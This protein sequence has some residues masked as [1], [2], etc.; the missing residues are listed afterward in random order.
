MSCFIPDASLPAEY[1]A[2]LNT[3][4]KYLPD[5]SSEEKQILSFRETG[6]DKLTVS[7]TENGYR[8]GC[9]TKHAFLR[10]IG[11]AL[12]GM[13]TEETLPFTTL[14]VMLDCSRNRVFKVEFI[15]DFLLK[16][17]LTGYNMLMLYTEDV[18]ELPGEPAFGFMRGRYSAEEI[19]E[20]DAFAQ[21]LGIEVR[22]CIQTLGHLEHLFT[23]YQYA[24]I[25]DMKGILLA[26]EEKTYLLIEKMIRFYAENLHSKQILIGMD[27]THDLGRGKHLDKFGWEPPEAIY[28]RHLSKVCTICEKYKL[29]PMI[30]SDMLFRLSDQKTLRNTLPASLR[31]CHWNYSATDPAVYRTN[32]EHHQALGCDTAM[33]SAVP[34]YN[35]FCRVAGKTEQVIPACVQ[36]C[37]EAGIRELIITIWG[38]AGAFCNMTSAMAGIVFAASAAYGSRN[39]EAKLFQTLTGVDHSLLCE[40][41][42][43]QSNIGGTLIPVPGLLWEDPL[44]GGIYTYCFSKYEPVMRRCLQELEGVRRHLSKEKLSEPLQELFSIIDLL[45]YGLTFREELLRAYTEKNTAELSVL[46][47][48]GIAAYQQ[49][50]QTFDACF[51]KEWMRT[52]KPFGL[53]IIQRRNAGL[54]ARLDELALRIKEF[55]NGE[56][57]RIAE[58][59][60]ALHAASIPGFQPALPVFSACLEIY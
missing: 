37:M 45:L 18:Y 35:T 24:D 27:E 19:R 7:K 16:C 50:I 23:H 40:A 54:S 43:L 39:T 4:S 33:A 38:D 49:K 42:K 11:I 17:A 12:S 31:L 9:G 1:A 15:R 22:A 32:L 58:L 59:D 47:E 53:E 2:L 20:I 25:R 41:E 46:R 6:S 51:R 29:T 52:A 21:S 36:G 10:G 8:I 14:G 3:V 13:E 57:D 5:F 34:T 28:L 48:K 60:E 44:Q 56:I 26:D 55:L 30:W